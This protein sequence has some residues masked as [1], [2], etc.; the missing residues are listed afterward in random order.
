MARCPCQLLIR[1]NLLLTLA[2]D[3]LIYSTSGATPAPKE[4]TM[5]TVKAYMTIRLSD[6]GD[7]METLYVLS[8]EGVAYRSEER[9][10]SNTFPAS[11]RWTPI[12]ALPQGAEY[13]GNYRKP[14]FV[15]ISG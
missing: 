8:A 3:L 5:N 4:T 1:L 7:R 15:G 10:F 14:T 13:I 6:T 12:D 2:T 11:T 9:P